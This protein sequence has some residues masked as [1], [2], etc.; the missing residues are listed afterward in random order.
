MCK[1]RNL[2]TAEYFITVQREYLMA[3]LR[4]KIYPTSKDKKFYQKVMNYK[5]EKI[6]DIS[7]RCKL[8]SIFND[9]DMLQEFKAKLFNDIGIP[10]FLNRDE[11]EY[12]YYKGSEFS[13]DGEIYELVDV[14]WE[15]EC[16]FLR[17]GDKRINVRVEQAC[18]IL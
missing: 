6:E 12:Y 13:Y 10:N 14:S 2:S 9:K 7:N 5:K 18:R 4:K 1:T 3:E 8:K 11:M 15:T 17:K 16:L